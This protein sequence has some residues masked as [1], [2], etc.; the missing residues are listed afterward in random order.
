MELKGCT[1]SRALKAQAGPRRSFD[2][3]NNVH[4]LLKARGSIFLV[5]TIMDLAIL[6]FQAH[7]CVVAVRASS[8]EAV[9]NSRPYFKICESSVNL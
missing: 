4:E 9:H 5:R 7:E 1:G 6:E 3:V 8:P 2:V